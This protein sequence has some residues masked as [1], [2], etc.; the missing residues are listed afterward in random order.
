MFYRMIVRG[1][2]LICLV[3]GCAGPLQPGQLPTAEE[4]CAIQRGS[5][6][7]GIC[8]TTGGM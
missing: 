8:H 5:F 3:A 2:L 7:A 6:R 4:Q 1:L